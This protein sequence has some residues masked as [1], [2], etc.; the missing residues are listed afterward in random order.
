MGAAKIRRV[1]ASFVR[2]PRGSAK[3]RWLKGYAFVSTS[4]AD[5]WQYPS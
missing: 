3:E 4:K 5:F 1:N 2:D